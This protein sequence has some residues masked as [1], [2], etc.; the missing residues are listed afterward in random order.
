MP[1][2][3]VMALAISTIHIALLFNGHTIF[4]DLSCII[5]VKFQVKKVY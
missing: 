3:V 5:R 4:I 2:K 1:L